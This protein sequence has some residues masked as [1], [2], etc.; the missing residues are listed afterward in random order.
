[1]G[2][3][4]MSEQLPW[5]V[6]LS[7][8]LSGLSH[9]I[10]HSN[11]SPRFCRSLPQ[12]C[13]SSSPQSRGFSKAQLPD[14]GS[15]CQEWPEHP[16]GLQSLHLTHTSPKPQAAFWDVP[17]WFS[18]VALVTIR[19]LPGCRSAG[20]ISNA[21]RLQCVTVPCSVSKRG[22]V[23]LLS[24]GPS[25]HESPVPTEPSQIQKQLTS[26]Y[27]LTAD[28]SRNLALR[29]QKTPPMWY[30]NKAF[31]AILFCAESWEDT[32]LSSTLELTF[33]LLLTHLW[34]NIMYKILYREAPQPDPTI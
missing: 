7:P 22:N 4:S 24:P 30:L 28:S 23:I 29:F 18:E 27:L 1:M 16:K 21:P 32:V 14:T 6:V 31:S 17:V 12:H 20:K 3:S 10:N 15:Q 25:P 9:H 19:G 5:G 26:A 34:V 2:Q 33:E 11:I 13:L 8:H